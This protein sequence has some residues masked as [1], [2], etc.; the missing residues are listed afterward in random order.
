MLTYLAPLCIV[1]GAIGF[2]ASKTNADLKEMGRLVFFAA[3]L[4]V[5]LAVGMTH[6]IRLP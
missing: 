3:V 4:A 1:L 5:L 2:L 6:Q